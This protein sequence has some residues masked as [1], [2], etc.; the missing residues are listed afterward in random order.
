MS[1]IRPLRG[2]VLVRLLP[3]EWWNPSG[4]IIPDIAQEDGFG[5]KRRPRKGLVVAI[6]PWKTTRQGLS[7]LPE[8]KPGEIVICN[9]YRGVKCRGWGADFRLLKIDDVLAIVEHEIT[10]QPAKANCAV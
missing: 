7:I 10:A 8:I 9:E 6:G 2:Q 5:E 1:E 3:P 4:L